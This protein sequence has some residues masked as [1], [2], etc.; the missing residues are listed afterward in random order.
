MLTS[1]STVQSPGRVE[2]QRFQRHLF[3]QSR[4]EGLLECCTLKG[5]LH[6]LGALT[7]FLRT[8]SGC[9]LV[10]N[11]GFPPR[12]IRGSYSE[13]PWERNLN[14]TKHMQR[15][16][17][18]RRK[19]ENRFEN[20]TLKQGTGKLVKKKK[21]GYHSFKCRLLR[22]MFFLQL[23]IFLLIFIKFGLVLPCWD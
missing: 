2:L 20:K 1:N 18:R 3:V 6:Y 22:I 14:N 21:K 23:L 19:K 8:A 15:F 9:V 11:T 13:S 16:K 5:L 4:E 10:W 12:L 7:S 17:K